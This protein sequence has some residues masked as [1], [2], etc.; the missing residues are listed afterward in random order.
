MRRGP[1]L[2]TGGVLGGVP[3]HGGGGAGQVGPARRGGG[4]YYT[5]RESWTRAGVGGNIAA[6]HFWG[7]GAVGGGRV[8]GGLGFGGGGLPLPARLILLSA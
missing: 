7:R 6:Q 3:G 4:R 8:V 1:G 2:C 5:R